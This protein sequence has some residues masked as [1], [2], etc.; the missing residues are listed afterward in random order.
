MF[1]TTI[2]IFSIQEFLAAYYIT[3]SSDKKQIQILKEKF[4][5]PKTSIMYAGLTSGNSF[6]LKHFLSGCKSVLASKAF[7]TAN[8]AQ[9]ILSNKV[10][11]LHLLGDLL[12]ESWGWRDFF[13]FFWPL[14]CYTF[15]VMKSVTRSSESSQ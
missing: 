6:A 14:F 8:L 7:S 15:S 4:W 1:L 13:S 5:D 3:T 11:C 10:S 9:E 2:Y 12:F